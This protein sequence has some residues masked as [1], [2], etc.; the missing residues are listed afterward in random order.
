M[1]SGLPSA[2]AIERL[3]GCEFGLLATGDLATSDPVHRESLADAWTSSGGLLLIRAGELSPQSLV[4]TAG[5]FG[6]VEDCHT[7]HVHSRLVHPTCSEIMTVT[8]RLDPDTGH[9]L[10]PPGAPCQAGEDNVQFP[11][12]RGWHTDCSF[13]WPPPDATLL[14][15]ENPATLGQADTL[16]ADAAAAYEALPPPQQQQ[17]RALRGVHCGF[18]VGRTEKDVLDGVPPSSREERPINSS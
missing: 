12:R 10:F 16:I 15:C 4:Q 3:P 2:L 8:N 17:L 1:V 9:P 5:I 7:T 11:L 14:Y 13:R 6:T 18:G